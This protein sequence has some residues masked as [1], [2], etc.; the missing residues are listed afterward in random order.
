VDRRVAREPEAGYKLAELAEKAGV[1]ARTIRLYI[2]KGLLPGPLRYGRG[3]T[4]GQEHLETLAAIRRL[5]AEGLTLEEI[6]RRLAGETGAGSVPEPSPWLTFD[7][8]DD[9]S[10]TVRADTPPWRMKRI[11][12]AMGQMLDV[13]GSEDE[14]GD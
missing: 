11:R 9:V 5:Q 1:P 7:L 10:V 2:S 12:R 6:R 8:A 13:L 3:A 14:K 4:Y